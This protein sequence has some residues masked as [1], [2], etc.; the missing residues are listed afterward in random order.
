MSKQ[1]D[2]N[3]SN[4]TGLSLAYGKFLVAMA[5]G[6]ALLAG[7]VLISQGQATAAEI[8]VYKSPTCGCCSKWVSHLRENGFSVVTHD[9]QDMSTVKR[10][11]GVP[12][13]M[14][15]CHTAKV[16]GYVIEGHVPADDISRL[17]QE[18]P[19]VDGLAVPGMPMGSPGMEGPRQDP[20]N[21]QA[22]QKSG[23]A[24]V[25]SRYNP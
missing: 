15:S 25:Y 5:L 3:R 4:K 23:D 22:F 9:R 10:E 7:A 24:E 16:G 6:L 17:L 13:R 19:A 8:V 14:Q 12:G 20:Y 21:V 11:L 1:I 18:K 2:S